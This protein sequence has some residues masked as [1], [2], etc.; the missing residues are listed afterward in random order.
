MVVPTSEVKFARGRMGC[1]ECKWLFVDMVSATREVK[2]IFMS[3]FAE[4]KCPES[5]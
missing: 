2:I 5:V 3:G 4:E 1:A